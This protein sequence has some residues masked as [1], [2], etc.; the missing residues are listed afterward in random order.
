MASA[1]PA[2]GSVQGFLAW[3]GTGLALGLGLGLMWRTGNAGVDKDNEAMAP[4]TPQ[5][6]QGAACAG[7]ELMR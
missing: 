3:P 7:C 4:H 5:A 2:A 1:T 6:G